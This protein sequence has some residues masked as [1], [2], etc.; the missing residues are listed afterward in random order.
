M[1]TKTPRSSSNH[2]NLAFQAED[3]VKVLKDDIMLGHFCDLFSISH[4]QDT[5]SNWVYENL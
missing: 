1:K 2:D 3:V 4:L 5:E